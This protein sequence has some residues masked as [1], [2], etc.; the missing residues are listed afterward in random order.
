MLLVW[1]CEPEIGKIEGA[2]MGGDNYAA[3]PKEATEV[4]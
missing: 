3:S 2:G 1:F 4:A